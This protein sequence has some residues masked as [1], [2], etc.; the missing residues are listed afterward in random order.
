MI[1]PLLHESFY[2]HGTWFDEKLGVYA[3][4]VAIKDSFADGMPLR[5]TQGDLTMIFSGEEYSDSVTI[6]SLPVNGHKNPRSRAAHLLQ[7]FESPEF[8]RNMNGMFHGL[9]ADRPRE[10]VSLFNDRF[11]MH[12]LYFHKEHDAFYFAS[13]AKAILSVKPELREADAQS[14]GEFIALSCVLENRTIFK[15]IHVLPPASHWTFENAELKRQDTYFRPHEWE[16][17]SP[18]PADEYYDELR[19]VVKGTLPRYFQGTEQM[20]VA[21]TGGLDTRVILALHP[22]APGALQTYT[23]AGPFRESQDVRIGRKVAEICGQPYKVITA[24]DNFLSRFADYAQRGMYLTEG[25]VDVG[26]SADLF[27]SEQARAIAPVKVVGTYGSE[28]LRQAVMFKPTDPTAGL[29]TPDVLSAVSEAKQTYAEQRRC[30]PVTFA[31]FRQSPWYHFGIL[32]TEK[33]QLTVRSPFLDNDYVRTVYRAPKSESAGEDLR[34][35]LIQ[36]GN[37]ELAKLRSDRG[38]GGNGGKLTAAVTRAYLEFTFK[39]EYAY[40]YGMPQS[41]S[42]IDHFFSALRL[43]RLFLGRHKLLHFRVWYRDQLADYVR[44]MLLD[45]L[46]LSRPFL[47]KGTIE[48]IVK[49]H[50]EEGRNYTTAIHKLISLELLQRLFLDTA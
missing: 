22:S 19:R 27:L 36:D 6:P 25:T 18:L 31:A 35:R 40:D 43:E 30:H 46:T 16:Q 37:Q 47:N 5:N 9:V 48:A 20:G 32:S 23:F 21:V 4:W 44:Q 8:P 49:G 13:E 38:V 3:G 11:G 50:L 17:Q 28:I 41:V 14:M 24:S 2:T 26:R 39:A 15:G 12:R 7:I 33:S 42:R 29:F 45:P 10:T 34:P 1:R